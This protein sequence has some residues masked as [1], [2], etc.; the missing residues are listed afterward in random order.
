VRHLPLEQG[1]R[2]KFDEAQNILRPVLHFGGGTGALPLHA[3]TLVAL[4]THG[5]GDG[6][7]VAPSRAFSG[8]A[9]IIEM[10]CLQPQG[11]PVGTC[12]KVFRWAHVVSDFGGLKV[13]DRVVCESQVSAT[14]LAG[15]DDDWRDSTSFNLRMNQ[16]Q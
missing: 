8:L 12:R 14:P 5:N 11:K 3:W 9:W 2:P 15:P 6:I 7:M 4:K 13:R 1:A 10:T 16:S